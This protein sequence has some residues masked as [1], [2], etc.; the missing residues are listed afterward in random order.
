[1]KK[2][3]LFGAVALFVSAVLKVAAGQAPVTGTAK[4]P[5]NIWLPSKKEPPTSAAL[6][7]EEELKTV[8]LP[9]GY[10]AQLVAAEPFIESPIIIDVDPDGRM[11]VLELQAFLPDTAGRDTQA[12]TC[13]VACP[14]Y[15]SP[16]PRD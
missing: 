9:P 12:P 11:W 16:S 8:K 4:T 10:H 5:G 1:M 15:K 13:D 7:P 14:L 2:L 3:T 6:T